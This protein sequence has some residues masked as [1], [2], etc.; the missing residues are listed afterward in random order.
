MP[1]QI[2][3]NRAENLATEF[4]QALELVRNEFE[5]LDLTVSTA[6]PSPGY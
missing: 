1:I 6:T 5:G 2:D 3:R 4:D